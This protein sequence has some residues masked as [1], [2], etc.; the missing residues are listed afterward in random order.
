MGE[1]SIPS[2]YKLRKESNISNISLI[3]DESSTFIL[4]QVHHNIIEEKA[5]NH[6]N[7]HSKNS[8]NLFQEKLTL[9]EKFL[10]NERL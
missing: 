9:N 8:D 10:L 5:H 6:L 2:N 7:N 1:H 4:T 3:D